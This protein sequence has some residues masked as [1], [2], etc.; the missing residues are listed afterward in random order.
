MNYKTFFI[1]L[2]TP[3]LLVGCDLF[4]PKSKTATIYRNYVGPGKAVMTLVTYDDEYGDYA[5]RHCEIIVK[6]WNKEDEYKGIKYLCSDR[7]YKKWKPR[8]DCNIV[9]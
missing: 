6:H 7:V 5:M 1:I 9:G 2:I 4:E 8:I 3:L